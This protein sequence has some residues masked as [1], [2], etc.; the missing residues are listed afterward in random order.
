MVAVLAVWA[1]GVVAPSAQATR[2][3][4]G[5]Y[6]VTSGEVRQHDEY[7]RHAVSNDECYDSVFDDQGST[8]TKLA[9][10]PGELVDAK[11]TGAG[12]QITGIRWSGTSAIKSDFQVRSTAVADPPPGCAGIPAPK[13]GVSS[14]CGT[15]RV[16]GESP[17]VIADRSHRLGLEGPLYDGDPFHSACES[18]SPY[19]SVVIPG[20]V[21]DVTSAEVID[22]KHHVLHLSGKAED[23]KVSSLV[24]LIPHGSGYHRAQMTWKLTLVRVG[25]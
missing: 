25:N 18:D 3:Q 14:G 11:L 24:S 9:A 6:R 22:D 13:P 16:A 2:M 1:S 4:I 10:K 15:K 12:V 20:A 21:S 7:L 23:N 17:A 19:A 5:T 8:T